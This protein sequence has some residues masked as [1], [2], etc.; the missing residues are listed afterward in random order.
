MEKEQ[1][2]GLIYF[3]YGNLQMALLSTKH[4]I[5]ISEDEK[6]RRALLEDMQAFEKFQAAIVK[7][8]GDCRLKGLTEMA[9]KGTEFAIDMKTFFNKDTAKLCD[10]LAAG[11]EKGIASL[12][13]NLQNATDESEDVK[14]LAKGYLNYLKQA[15][16]RYSGF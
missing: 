7:M 3:L 1:E 10:M 5:E 2:K 13:E 8:R 15:H 6:L 4:L 9:Q 14:E 12:T 16:E 11:Y